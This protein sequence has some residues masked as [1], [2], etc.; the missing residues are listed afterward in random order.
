MAIVLWMDLLWSPLA[1]SG[2]VALVSILDFVWLWL[3]FGFGFGWKQKLG[4]KGG[5]SVH[6]HDMALFLTCSI[7]L[8]FVFRGFALVQWIELAALSPKLVSECQLGCSLLW[9]CCLKFMGL[10]REIRLYWLWEGSM[11]RACCAVSNTGIQ[12]LVSS[13]QLAFF[14]LRYRGFNVWWR[15]EFVGLGGVLWCLWF[16]LLSHWARWA[17]LHFQHLNKAS[18]ERGRWAVFKTGWI[19]VIGPLVGVL[20]YDVVK[21]LLRLFSAL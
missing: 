13:S 6:I 16:Y 9:Y 5:R 7:E 20:C 19:F 10:W 15:V 11:H 12:K 21:S 17:N 3:G 14:L 18:I 4:F 8:H 2:L 1:V